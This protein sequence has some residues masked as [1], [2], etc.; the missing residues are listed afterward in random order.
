MI[1]GSTSRGGRGGRGKG[2]GASGGGGGGRGKGTT[3]SRL[4][5]TIPN[6]ARE[7]IQTIK[8]I[9]GI[10][11]DDEVYAMLRECSMDPNE[12]AQQLLLQGPFFPFASFFFPFFLFSLC[13]QIYVSIYCVLMFVVVFFLIDLIGGVDVGI[14]E[15]FGM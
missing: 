15:R 7:T 9:T 4:N 11:S 6:E 12:T 3:T 8:E 10:Q 5:I 13:N 2:G 14:G 1:S